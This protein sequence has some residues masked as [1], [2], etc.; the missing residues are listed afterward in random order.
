M[1]AEF[2]FAPDFS[3]TRFLRQSSR[4]ELSHL[5]GLP[6][7]P[8]GPRSIRGI[9]CVDTLERRY[10][11]DDLHLLQADSA[12]GKL[13]AL[14][15]IGT[16]NLHWRSRWQWDDELA[17]WSRQDQLLN[18]GPQPATILRCLARFSL[19][20]GQHELSIQSGSWAHENQLQSVSVSTGRFS[21]RAQG[22]RTTQGGAP[23]L[24]YHPAGSPSA[25]AFHWLPQGNWSLHIDQTRTPWSAEEPFLAV[26][27]GPSDENLRLNL[28]PGAHFD[29]PEILIQ[30]VA[31]SRPADGAAG[32]Q[33]YCLKHFFNAEGHPN[34][35][36]V[37]NT[38][39]DQFEGLTTDRLRAQLSAAKAAGCEVF[40]VDAGWYGAGSGPWHQQVGDWREKLDGA[41]H[42]QMRAFAAEVRAAGLG[43][44][45][46]V[47]PERIGSTAPFLREH[48]E[49]CRPGDGGFFAPDL[50]NPQAAEAVY[51]ELGRLVQDYGL[52]WMKIDFNFELGAAA[53]ELAGYYQGWYRLL[54]RLRAAHP[55]LF[56]EAC[57]SGGM[58]CDLNTLRH[59]DAHFLSDSVNPLDVIRIGEGAGL[60]LPAGRLTRWAVVRPASVLPKDGPPNSQALPVLT[61][62]C[63]GWDNAFL[64]DLDFVVRAAFP[65]VLGLSGDLAGLDPVTLQRLAQHVTVY[66]NLRGFIR[67]ALAHP[68]TSIRGQN[69]I[70]GWAGIQLQ[71]P[72]QDAFNLVL[73]YRLRGTAAQTWLRLHNLDA[74]ADYQVSDEDGL[75]Q[76]QTLSGAALMSAGLPVQ[77]DHFNGAALLKVKR[78]PARL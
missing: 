26:E 31:G 48:P 1:P 67:G 40:T 71:S 77:I 43:F 53:D 35:P 51:A 20:A 72:G 41:F 6:C 5:C 63:A 61:P 70:E 45:L 11:A 13:E 44:G 32:I 52:V 42:G 58:R 21:L 69:D 39:F 29:L 49:W 19:A 64:A 68:L 37:Y 57:A 55:A 36:V 59:C 7:C 9:A 74:Q 15:Q 60:R 50:T 46:W 34:P 25:I 75:Q 30:A 4:L 73:A 28:P 17:V 16:S 33:R 56:V 8:E 66:K 24:F 47:E 22:G 65:G 3:P 38:W 2:L 18:T 23:Y 62:N 12:G 54:D 10:E 14:W 27:I 76:T 78:L